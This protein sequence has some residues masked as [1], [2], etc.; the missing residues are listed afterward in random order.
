MKKIK[1]S[2]FFQ[3]IPLWLAWLTV[4]AFFSFN[5]SERWLSDLAYPVRFGFLFVWLFI[6]VIWNSFEVAH[7]VEKLSESVRE[8]F[9]TLILTLSVTSIEIVMIVSIMI[10]G[11]QNPYLVRDTMYAILMIVLNGIVG[12]GLLLGGIRYR[13]QRYNLRGSIQFVSVIFVLAVIGLVLPDF[14]QSRATNNFSTGQTTFLVVTYLAVYA[15]FLGM[16]TISH[17]KHF[18]LSS[19]SQ[20]PSHPSK[21]H[22]QCPNKSG[23]YNAILL[24]AYLIP[25]LLIAK[26]IA[27]PIEVTMVSLSP[28]AALGGLLVAALVLAPEAVSAIRASL[29][30]HLQRSVNIALGTVLATTALTIPI[31]LAIGLFIGQ[32]VILGLANTH[33]TLLMLTLMTATLTFASGR[34]NILQGA[35]HLLLF[36]VYIMLIFD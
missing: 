27:L 29:A 23:A 10:A 14:T 7:H 30:N 36:F 11:K 4:A 35:L 8:P 26:K 25:T 13:E 19:E 18:I 15:I 6:I 22:V 33:I 5:L 31:V 28:P 20:E 32:P 3:E 17:T 34:S 24:V 2:F 12:L 9:G 16:Q 21:L 1:N